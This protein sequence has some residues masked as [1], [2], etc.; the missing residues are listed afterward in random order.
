MAF[1]CSTNEI[2][3][4]SFDDNTGSSVSDNSGNSH[5]GTWN[6][7]L[8]SQWT[9]GK[10]N[11][12]GSFN[13][14]DNYVIATVNA[15]L[16]GSFS[17]SS[18]F[19]IPNFTSGE[20]TLVSSRVASYDN[21]WAN[22]F[23]DASNK[24]AAVNLYDGI[25][26]PYAFGVNN[27]LTTNTWYHVVLVRNTTDH[28]LKYYLNGALV[29]SVLDTTT[30]APAYSDLTIGARHSSGAYRGFFN[31]VIDEV[32]IWSRALDSTEV[33][34]LYNGGAGVSCVGNSPSVSPS[35]SQSPSSS[36]SPSISPSASKS[37]SSSVSPSISP[38][39]SKSPSSSVSPSISPSASKSPSS[40]ISLSPSPSVGIGSGTFSMLNVG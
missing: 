28:T 20:Y 26:N 25:T 35:S 2:A 19:K 6:G 14:S 11:S 17:L 21:Y 12:G 15:G 29:T 8:G 5:T 18:W 1:N 22:L 16:D 13:G 40:S 37:P 32:G 39:A 33:S 7:T 10:I 34:D 38:S 36:V 27:E 9:T 4:W 23:V 3:Y 31:G 30:V 24:F